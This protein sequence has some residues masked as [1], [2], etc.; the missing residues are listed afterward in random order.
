MVLAVEDQSQ[1]ALDPLDL[2]DDQVARG[3]R[4]QPPPV[5]DPYQHHPEAASIDFARHAGVVLRWIRPLASDST[6]W[7]WRPERTPGITT[8]AHAR[9]VV[10]TMWILECGWDHK[11]GRLSEMQEGRMVADALRYHKLPVSALR[12]RKG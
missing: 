9:R 11:R 4:D 8:A 1:G 3:L 10:Y 6:P 2:E 5:S 12:R 7:L